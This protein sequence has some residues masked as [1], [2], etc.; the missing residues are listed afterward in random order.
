M[1]APLLKRRSAR[2]A[3]LGPALDAELAQD[4]LEEERRGP[5]GPDLVGGA[6][7]QEGQVPA[8][9]AHH[10]HLLA[11]RL[12]GEPD[13]AF[14]AGWGQRRIGELQ[15]ADLG[16]SL[17]HQHELVVRSR[18]PGRSA[19]PPDG[20]DHVLDVLS[21]HR[22]TCTSR[23]CSG[24]VWTRSPTWLRRQPTTPGIRKGSWRR[25]RK[26]SRASPSPSSASRRCPTTWPEEGT[27][28]PRRSSSG[29][30]KGAAWAP[31]SSIGGAG[32]TGPSSASPAAWSA[33]PG[34][35]GTPRPTPFA[36]CPSSS[37]AATWIR[38]CRFRGS[39]R[40]RRCSVACRR[41]SAAGSIPRWV[42]RSATTRSGTRERSWRH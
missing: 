37:A 21:H 13:R 2:L 14:L 15:E 23:S 17:H 10:A 28:I 11:F 18:V 1:A 7:R 38:G 35:D 26:T 42:T 33:L 3:D 12:A 16:L 41:R 19:L 9:R 20:L 32:A 25:S 34:P 4:G 27:R 29:S 31:S 36:G 24:W 30:R 5:F 40:R 22:P 8:A 6:R 39:W